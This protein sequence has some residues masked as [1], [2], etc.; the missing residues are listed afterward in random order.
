MIEQRR[1]SPRETFRAD[2]QCSRD[3]LGRIGDRIRHTLGLI[4]RLLGRGLRGACRP[5]VAEQSGALPRRV[6]AAVSMAG[7]TAF[8]VSAASVS[9]LGCQLCRRERLGSIRCRDSHAGDRAVATS[10]S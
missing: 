10:V 7:P 4:E 1:P 3:G 5:L 6:C 2:R 8:T 9:C